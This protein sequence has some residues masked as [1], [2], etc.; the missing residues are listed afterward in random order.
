MTDF[1]RLWK[2][3]TDYDILWQIMIDYDRLW[4]IITDLWQ[5]MADYD[6]L[7][8]ITTDYDWLWL[9][10]TDYDRIWLIMTDYDILWQN[11]TYYD[12]LWQNMTYY[13]ILWHIMIDLL[14]PV[15][16][17]DPI[18]HWL[19]LVDPDDLGWHQDWS[20]IVFYHL[21]FLLNHHFVFW[22]A[23]WCNPPARPRNPEQDLGY[24]GNFT[25]STNERF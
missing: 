3:M 21:F 19:I 14:S 23:N 15:D 1:D 8:Q 20:A 10:M 7:W 4:Q 2:I 17:I 18:W 13:D 24:L 6:R 9:I 5:I 11:M 16:L 22:L 12:I 25:Q